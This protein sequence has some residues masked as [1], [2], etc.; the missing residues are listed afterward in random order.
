MSIRVAIADD[1]ALVRAGFRALID[2]EPGLEVVGEAADGAEA[3]ELART[4]QPDVVLMDIRMPGTDGVAATSQITSREMAGRPTRVISIITSARCL[5]IGSAPFIRR[6]AQRN[7]ICRSRPELGR[8][9]ALR[10]NPSGA[11]LERALRSTPN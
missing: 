10:I 3:I 8:L 7:T 6:P 9:S 2:A 4:A 1:H 11:A 5:I